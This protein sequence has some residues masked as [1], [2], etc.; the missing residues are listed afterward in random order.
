MWCDDENNNADCNWDGGACCFNDA[1]G[2][3]TYCTV[4]N[5]FKFN[6]SYKPHNFFHYSCRIVSAKNV[7][8]LDGGVITTVMIIWILTIA[9]GTVEIVVVMSTQT[10][11]LWVFIKIVSKFW[12]KIYNQE[13]FLGLHMSWSW[14]FNNHYYNHH[15]RTTNDRLRIPSL[16]HRSMVRWREQQCWLQLWWWSLL[17]QWFQWMGH[18]LQ[19][20]IDF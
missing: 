2:W 3:D 11:A 15:H 19:C 10:T 12:K 17:L 18:L 5:F 4:W 8:H 16:G 6:F 14:I 7:H 20:I 13:I 1:Q 9:N